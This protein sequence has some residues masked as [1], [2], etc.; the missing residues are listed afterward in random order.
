MINI[1]STKDRLTL[2]ESIVSGGSEFQSYFPTAVI[3]SFQY[4]LGGAAAYEEDPVIKELLQ[5]FINGL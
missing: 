4:F 3:T 2:A 1:L 5:N